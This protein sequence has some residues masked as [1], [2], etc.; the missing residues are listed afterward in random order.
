VEYRPRA[1]ARARRRRRQG[2]FYAGRRHRTTKA[3]VN[4]TGGRYC[5]IAANQPSFEELHP[6]SCNMGSIWEAT[7]VRH[8]NEVSPCAATKSE[9]KEGRPGVFRA[10][11]ARGR[12][13]GQNCSVGRRA[14][15][16]T[17]RLPFNSPHPLIFL[18]GWKC[19]ARRRAP[20]DRHRPA[21]LPADSA[22]RRWCSTTRR[23]QSAAALDHSRFR[24]HELC[25]ATARAGQTL[26]Q[27]PMI[28]R[29]HRNP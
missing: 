4:K 7:T 25:A 26:G 9:S 11:I 28:H 19:P 17:S 10:R 18:A 1:S 6:P 23:R 22:A 13:R 5:I 12:S 14:P 15:L 2:D 27:G 3:P 21:E 29:P 20:H 16:R 24:H 8:G